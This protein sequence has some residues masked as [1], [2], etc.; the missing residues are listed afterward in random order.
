MSDLAG[1]EIL[2]LVATH[3]RTAPAQA[4]GRQFDSSLATT[5]EGGDT[6]MVVETTGISG[7]SGQWDSA[8]EV[9]KDSDSLIVQ[10]TFGTGTP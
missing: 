7:R 4:L 5:K 1:L 6:D 9:N 8:M 3:P 2:L 10:Y